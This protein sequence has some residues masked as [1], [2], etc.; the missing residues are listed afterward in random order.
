MSCPLLRY[1]HTARCVAAGEP[2][3]VPPDVVGT[4]CRASHERCPAFRY[5]RVTARPMHPADFRAW[6]VRGVPP[7]RSDAAPESAGPDLG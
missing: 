2:L 7:G 3:P 6:V 5:L 1:T 4:F